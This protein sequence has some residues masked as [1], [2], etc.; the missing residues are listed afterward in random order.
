MKTKQKK[1]KVDVYTHVT[2]TIIKRLEEG[3]VPWKRPWSVNVGVP[4]NF[5]SGNTYQGCNFLLLACEE[6]PS[7][8]W[9]TFLQAKNAGGTVK[10][11]AKGSMIL[12]YGVSKGK[13]DDERGDEKKLRRRFLRFYH[14]F[15]L[16]QIDGIEA[17]STPVTPPGG[18]IEAERLIEGLKDA[19][20][21]VEGESIKAYYAR[22]S[23]TIHMPPRERFDSIE[24]YYMTLLHELVHATGHEKRLNRGSLTETT[25]KTQ[26][27][28]GFEELIAEIGSSM[29]AAFLGIA[30][31]DGESSASYINAWLKR[32]RSKDNRKW[33]VS[34]SAMARH[35]VE[36]IMPHNNT[37]E[38]SSL[39]IL[40]PT[41]IQ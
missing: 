34:A 26:Q 15:N 25:K 36:W 10:K 14:V 12:K 13:E 40:N 38:P 5:V 22:D 21:I 9:M 4:R 29:L 2:E 1:P 18:V 32:L 35:A 37:I 20:A 31:D 33:I 7:P 23:D 11:H 30:P 19:P 8:F 16:C 41:Q 39:H 17:P 27:S 24:H 28:Y 6:Y 3:V